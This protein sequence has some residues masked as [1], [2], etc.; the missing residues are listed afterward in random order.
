MELEVLVGRK[1]WDGV[2]EDP[3]P[4]R[5][6]KPRA[7]GVTMVMD[8]GL[9]VTE[10]GDLFDVAGDYIDFLKVG[11]GTSVLV[12]RVLLQRKMLLA[13]EHEVDIYPGGT[14]FEVALLQGRREEFLTRSCDLGFT[15]LEVSDGTM[16]LSAR[17]RRKAIESALSRGLKV[18]TEV[19][20]KDASAQPAPSYLRQQIL[21]DLEA[22]AGYVIVEGRESGKGVGIYDEHGGVRADDVEELVAGLPDPSRI[23]WEAPLKSQQ[24]ALIKRFGANVSLGNLAPGEIMALETLRRG[25]RSDSLRLCIAGQT[26]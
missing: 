26:A 19:G 13:R 6:V 14:L 22:G 9:G 5:T 21:S 10:L 25:L 7:H 2:I 4:G 16:A 24:E 11:F 17:E 20:K 15:A 18:L 1:A 12:D 8:K 23:L 3:R